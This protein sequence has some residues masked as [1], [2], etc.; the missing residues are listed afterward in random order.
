M[1]DDIIDDDSGDW[2]VRR[3]KDGTTETVVDHQ[4]INR[5]RLRVS[6]RRWILSKALPRIHG[7]RPDPTDQQPYQPYGRDKCD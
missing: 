2:T 4:N 5:S 3:C 7:D 1:P 6:S